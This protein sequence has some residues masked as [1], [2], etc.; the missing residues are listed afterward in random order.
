MTGESEAVYIGQD[1]DH[2][3]V[4]AIKTQ[5]QY[6]CP[7]SPIISPHTVLFVLGT[8]EIDS[9]DVNSHLTTLYQVPET[10]KSLELLPTENLYSPSTTMIQFCE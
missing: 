7:S 1:K 6:S 5:P 3:T 8:C 10:T 9:E 4:Q 2:I